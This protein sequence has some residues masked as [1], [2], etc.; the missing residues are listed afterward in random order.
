MKPKMKCEKP[1][2][3]GVKQVA[4]LAACQQEAESKGRAYLNFEPERRQCFTSVTCDNPKTTL[5]DWHIYNLR[6]PP[7]EW[8]AMF[9]PKQKCERPPG[10]RA[11]EAAD[12]GAC[13]KRAE[14][15]G[16]KFLNFEAGRKLCYTSITCD[17]PVKAASYAWQV[18]RQVE[19]A[20]STDDDEVMVQMSF[21]F[22]PVFGLHRKCE[23]PDGEEAVAATFAEC[24]AKASAEYRSFFTFD[25]KQNLCFTSPT[26]NDPV[27]S[28]FSWQIYAAGGLEAFLSGT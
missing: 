17:R 15:E 10:E 25:S 9:Q 5:F 13:E 24:E 21:S 23:R 28:V 26:C 1:N 18:Y 19:A 3:A 4:D 11:E 22:D 14:A 20:S 7:V 12:V 6:E 2:G 8:V 16:R 27:P